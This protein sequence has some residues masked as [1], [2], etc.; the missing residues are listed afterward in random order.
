[1]RFFLFAMFCFFTQTNFDQTDNFQ[2]KLVYQLSMKITS[3][4]ESFN[5]AVIERTKEQ[6]DVDSVVVYIKDKYWRSA[7]CGKEVVQYFQYIPNENLIYEQL[8]KNDYIFIYS[9]NYEP[10]PIQEDSLEITYDSVIT[11]IN[12]LICRSYSITDQFCKSVYYYSESLRSDSPILESK[13]TTNFLRTYDERNFIP[14]KVVT[15]TPLFIIEYELR[16]I[17]FYDVP[18]E[19]FQLPEMGKTHKKMQK[20]M[21]RTEVKVKEIR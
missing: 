19:V 1:M 18:M 5:Q 7:L 15:I 13:Y 6:I 20:M 3:D 10:F 14:V 8:I 16:N 21:R 11:N 9:P 2:G 4:N 12:G 17:K